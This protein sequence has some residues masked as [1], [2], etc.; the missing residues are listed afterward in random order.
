MEVL[1][2]VG[3]VQACYIHLG[4]DVNESAAGLRCRQV[5]SCAS[6]L[7][8]FACGGPSIWTGRLR[9]GRVAVRREVSARK[10]EENSTRYLEGIPIDQSFL[11]YWYRPSPAKKKSAKNLKTKSAVYYKMN[12]A[13]T[14]N[15]QADKEELV[16]FP[17]EPATIAVPSTP[18]IK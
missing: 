2:L 17:T 14:W 18:R 16:Y 13:S 4:L 11:N 12:F 10:N 3:P 7:G 1:V 6:V 8:A 9:P 5:P 15:E